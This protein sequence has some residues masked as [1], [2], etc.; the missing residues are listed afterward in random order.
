M[1]CILLVK[2]GFSVDVYAIRSP[3]AQNKTSRTYKLHD[4]KGIDHFPVR[5]LVNK[6]HLSKNI[7]LLSG[8]TGS[9]V[10]LEVVRLMHALRRCPGRQVAPLLTSGLAVED[11]EDFLLLRSEP[12]WACLLGFMAGT[13]MNGP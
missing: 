7:F 12:V 8:A 10:R 11:V 9:A 6:Y 1:V 13:I 5:C 4:I 2:L 3:Y